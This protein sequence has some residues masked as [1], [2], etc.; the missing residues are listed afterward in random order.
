MTIKF[1]WWRITFYPFNSAMH[2]AVNILTRRFGYICFK[3]LTRS[4]GA[5]WPAYFYLSPNATPWAATLLWGREYSKS[6]KKLAKIR[7]ILWGH[8]YSTEYY[9]P[10]KNKRYELSMRELCRDNLSEIEE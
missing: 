1:F 7:R 4:C 10:Q 5:W 8:G 9:D 6:A 2:G 3:P